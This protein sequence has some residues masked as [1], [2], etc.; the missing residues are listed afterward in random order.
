MLG[1]IPIE[2]I[3]L[4][5]VCEP[6]SRKLNLGNIYGTI[7]AHACTATTFH[8]YPTVLSPSSHPTR[9]RFDSSA[10]TM[11]RERRLCR[12]PSVGGKCKLHESRWDVV[13]WTHGLEVEQSPEV[14]KQF[15]RSARST[16]PSS[17]EQAQGTLALTCMAKAL[18]FKPRRGIGLWIGLIES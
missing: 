3:Q 8:V 6:F 15:H 1:R 18:S 4:S 17:P 16:T 7:R 12:P 10:E 11:A 13:A 5:T 14:E 9:V 2:S